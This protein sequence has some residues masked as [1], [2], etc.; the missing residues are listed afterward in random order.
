V[1]THWRTALAALAA[2]AAAS[3]TA[4]HPGGESPAAPP[5][6]DAAS[7]YQLIQEPEHGYAA[8]Y[9]LLARARTSIRMTMYELAD[10]AATSALI[11]ARRRGV[12]VRVLLDTA[13]HG[14]NTNTDAYTQLAAAGVNVRWAPPGIIYHQ[15]TI[16]ID[17][18]ETAVGTGN[19]DAHWYPT[20]RDA[21]IL[22]TNSTDVAAIADTFDA[23]DDPAPSGPPRPASA[24]P[25]LLWS[26]AARATF[27]QH[28][29]AA[30]R[31]I[32][33]TT[34]E[35]TFFGGF[36]R[37]GQSTWP[38]PPSQPGSDVPDAAWLEPHRGFSGRGPAVIW[39]P[40][41]MCTTVPDLACDCDLV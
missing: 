3:C 23:D 18:V 35:L 24:A 39:G 12:D 20:S 2:V 7:P 41:Q 13:F 33:V 28:I 31:G 15:K 40:D 11:A 25:A 17:N 5:A 6:A 38:Y 8:I 27:L 36:Q 19:L 22:D 34:E 37:V 21:W 16:T 9:A 29:D 1:N 26:P 30:S 4:L 10:P 32:D 14:R